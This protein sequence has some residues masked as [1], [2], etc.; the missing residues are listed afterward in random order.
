[1][2]L[3][4]LAAFGTGTLGEL[5]WLWEHL[6]RRILWALTSL[7][8]WCLERARWLVGEFLL[9]HKSEQNWDFI[10]KNQIQILLDF[11]P[12]DT[13]LRKS[14]C[15][16]RLWGSCFRGCCSWPWCVQVT[17]VE[18]GKQSCQSPS[19]CFQAMPP[20]T[21]LPFKRSYLHLYKTRQA[22][23]TGLGGHFI[24]NYNI[25]LYSKF[26]LVNCVTKPCSTFTEHLYLMF[27]NVFIT[28]ENTPV[29]FLCCSIWHLLCLHQ[30]TMGSLCKRNPKTCDPPFSVFSL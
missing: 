27:S 22:S 16:R 12:D 15:R 6:G 7:D 23:H 2:S 5:T 20:I 1:M 11:H 10:F 17:S 9:G 18:L 4:L 24:P 29:P 13:K 26:P 21:W 14:S 28:P 25:F 19:I 3:R 8:P 30:Q